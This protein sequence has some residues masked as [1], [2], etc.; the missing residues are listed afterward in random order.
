MIDIDDHPERDGIL[1]GLAQVIDKLN[2]EP[3][4]TPSYI[5]ALEEVLEKWRIVCAKSG[6]S[7]PKMVLLPLQSV[8]AIE[9]I[10]IDRDAKHI[11][12]TVANILVKYPGIDVNELAHWVHHAFPDYRPF[13]QLEQGART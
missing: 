4:V 12:Q 7:F 10:R 3:S 11:E 1:E 13:M 8:N 6:I 2:I 9:M 5:Y